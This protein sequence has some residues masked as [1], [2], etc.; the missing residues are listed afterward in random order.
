MKSK[1]SKILLI[2]GLLFLIIGIFPFWLTIYGFACFILGAVLILLSLKN[3]KIK[4]IG[5][6]GIILFVTIFIHKS[7]TTPVRYLIPEGYKGHVYVIFNQKNGQKIEFEG[8]RRIY[9]IPKT[10]VLFTQFKDEEGWMD[11]D[12]YYITGTGKRI[13]LGIFDVR[14]Y[15]EEWSPKK[16]HIEPSRDSLAVFNPG[17]MGTI[18]NSDDKK[19]KIYIELFVGTYNDIKIK[20]EIKQEYIDSLQQE[21]EH[22]KY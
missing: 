11:E 20:G 21:L 15:D 14:D 13:K 16:N 18:G 5:I 4:W 17:T 22:N 2:L 3:W 8:R 12:Y 7:S 9:R 19:S 10:G 6:L 1:L